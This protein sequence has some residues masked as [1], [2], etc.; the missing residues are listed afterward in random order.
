MLNPHLFRG[1]ARKDGGIFRPTNSILD[2]RGDTDQQ[3][4]GINQWTARIALADTLIQIAS[5][6]HLCRGNE[7]AT[8]KVSVAAIIIDKGNIDL[9]QRIGR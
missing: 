9:E 5:S 1:N 7:I 2:A 4:T 3:A 6:T 8:V